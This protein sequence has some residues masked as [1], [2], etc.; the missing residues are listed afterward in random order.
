MRRLGPKSKILLL[1]TG[2]LVLAAILNFRDR[3]SFRLPSD[4]VQWTDVGG[5]VEAK[6]VAPDGSGARGGI[7]VGDRLEAIDGRPIASALQVSRE[8]FERNGQGRLRYQIH[9]G[10]RRSHVTLTP[11]HASSS[12]PLQTCLEVVGVL[13]LVMGL[14]VL[15]RARTA[16]R[17]IHFYL[18]CLSSFVLY[19]FSYSGRLDA[20]D[21]TVYWLESAA[22]VLQPA[23]FL[24]FCLRFAAAVPFWGRRTDWRKW[25]YAPGLVF[26]WVQLL[27]AFELIEITPSLPDSR[28]LLDRVAL[29]YLAVYFL[30]GVALLYKACS[31]APNPQLKQQ[32]KW[33]TW[34][35]S[36][37][38]AP[39]VV[40]YAAPYS[41]GTVPLAW[42]QL[43]S[44]SLAFLPLTFGY[45][46]IRYRLMD[47]DLLFRRGVIYSLA[48]A[49]VVALYFGFTALLADVFRTAVQMTSKAGWI[50]AIVLTA[51]LFRPLV[52]WIQRAVDRYFYRD[53][54]ALRR[55]LV[56]FARDLGT[57]IRL[58]LLLD[59]ILRRLSYTLNVEKTAVF[60]EETA[61]GT[62]RL[63]RAIG[64]PAA[65]GLDLSFLNPSRSE[66]REGYLF[67]TDPQNVPGES[68]ACRSALERLD[69]H[70]YIA[71]RNR[72]RVIGF[73]G[74]GKTR[75]GELLSSEDVEL[76]QTLSGYFSIAIEN[77]Q[78][79]RSL[80]QKALQ[81]ERLQQFNENILESV[82]AG[83]VAIG[84]EGRI[85]YWNAAMES[86]YGVR[87]F[88]T[89]GKPIEELLPRGLASELKLAS[90]FTDTR[91]L[92]KV[93][94]ITRAGHQA[95][96]NISATPLRGKDGKILGRLLVFNDMT[97]RVRLE[98]QVM[99]AEKLSSIGMLAA[100]VA[101]EV[102]TPLAV[103]ASQSQMLQ[104]LLPP[105]DPQR[106]FLDKIVRQ[107]FR[108]SE[109]ISHLLK[110][111][112]TS[113]TE[114]KQTDV[115][116]VV[117]E[118]LTL[119]EHVLR[120][121]RIRLEEHFDSQ[122][123]PIQ[124]NSGRLQQVF[125]NLILNARDAMRGGGG[126]RVRT[127]RE[128]SSV[129]VEVVDSGVGIPKEDV[130]RIYDP[131]FTTK[132]GSRGTGLGLAVTYGIIREH[133]GIIEVQSKPGQGTTFRLEFPAARK[134]V[135]V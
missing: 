79:C 72:G 73:V 5:A 108:A 41:L 30:A 36:V 8:L 53:R 60:L 64:I 99:Q 38:L 63:A 110:F 132:S 135:H 117:G 92:Y 58:D 59:G 9:R 109:I 50:L 107:T 118:T 14:F 83:V 85:E 115:N 29:G 26:L 52:N 56:D 24:H 46:V 54:Y 21:S 129:V 114:F 65:E 94:L 61:P 42:M 51:L 47:V 45:G 90:E 18:F 102:N 119:L 121:G 6:F 28:W 70:C 44:L 76:L 86:F 40:F 106:S 82:N 68:A 87:E 20:F 101:H 134:P 112:R 16:S 55:T 32:L 122:L 95:T 4:G 88:E 19:A 80:E 71:L 39:F 7:R 11:S 133:S 1:L 104:K 77:A 131:F 111:S 17:A 127:L 62:F 25:L 37:A 128:N 116:Q 67:F 57:E 89:V 35:S 74:L 33:L 22:W 13:Y 3:W 69:L 12:T 78:L 49:T 97:D 15:L 75:S 124:G 2:V 96:A 81:Y 130:P 84:L 100:G 123:P 103:I 48:T 66:L 93:K 113:G 23:L 31:A 10:G 27:V 125:M 98:D 43:S 126:L 34:G 105:E 91:S 120:A